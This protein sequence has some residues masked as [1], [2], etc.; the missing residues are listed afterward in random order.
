VKTKKSRTNANSLEVI[1]TTFNSGIFM[2]MLRSHSYTSLRLVIFTIVTIAFLCIY[3][4]SLEFRDYAV[5][6]A[7]VNIHHEEI[8]ALLTVLIVL[9]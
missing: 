6:I 8:I 2:A 9:Y 1:R 4:F 5:T 3:S 7:Q